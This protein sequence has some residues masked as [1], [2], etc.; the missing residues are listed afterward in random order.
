MRD[1]TQGVDWAQAAA[2]DANTRAEK[3]LARAQED[4]LRAQE[5][6]PEARARARRE[7]EDLNN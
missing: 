5:R 1:A 6:L 4:A 2:R 3:N 7:I